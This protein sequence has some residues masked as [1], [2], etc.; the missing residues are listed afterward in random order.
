MRKAL[1]GTFGISLMWENETGRKRR[2]WLIVGSILIGV[3]L[4]LGFVQLTCRTPATS[5]AT[6]RSSP[7]L[8]KH[9]E[10]CTT[11]PLPSDFQLKPKMVG[12]NSFTTAITYT[13][14]SEMS[15]ADVRNFFSSH[16]IAQGWAKTGQYDEEMTPIRKEVSFSKDNYRVGVSHVSARGANVP[17]EYA[18][19][20]AKES[21]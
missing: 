17:G 1:L 8:L 11:L 9:D 6:I 20:C 13:Y 19:Y 10:F 18:L 7:G 12:G 5:E 4:M 16:L 3:I 14:E 15:Y 21:R 2:L